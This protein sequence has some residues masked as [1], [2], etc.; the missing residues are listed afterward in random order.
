[1]DLVDEEHVAVLE[2]GQQGGEV[3]GPREHGPGG[4]AQA[5]PHLGGDDAGQGGLAQS[6]R[7]GEEDVVHRLA[8]LTGRLQHDA[9]MLDQLGLADE[10]LE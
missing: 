1:M 6:G 9:Q 7:A 3:P 4:D 5:R 10:L 2:V 8:A